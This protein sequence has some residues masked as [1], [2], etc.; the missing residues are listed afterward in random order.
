MAT[1][2][3]R[4]KAAGPATMSNQGRT[5][6]N[7]SRDVAKTTVPGTSTKKIQAPNMPRLGGDAIVNRPDRAMRRQLTGG[8]Y[9]R[10]S[11]AERATIAAPPPICHHADRHPAD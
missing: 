3:A 11:L 7:G 10:V 9:I 2:V 8:S 5:C 4:M 6:R 1:T